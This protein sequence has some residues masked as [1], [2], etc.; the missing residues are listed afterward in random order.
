MINMSRR[1]TQQTDFTL[2]VLVPRPM[3]SIEDGRRLLGLFTNRF[4]RRALERF[5][6]SEPLKDR[7][8]L[9]APDAA[10]EA[11]WGR[12]GFTFIAEGPETLLYVHATPPAKGRPGRTRVTLVRFQS[13]SRDDFE[14]VCAFVSEASSI[15][16]ADFAAAHVLTTQELEGRLEKIRVHPTVWPIAPGEQTVRY[17][18]DRVHREGF[19]T[20]LQN[21][22]NVISIPTLQKG[23]PHLSWFTVFGRPYIEMFGRE[24]I[25]S[26]PAFEV[27]EISEAAVR[28]QLT[29]DLEDSQKSWDNFARIRKEC[30]EHLG[31]DA[32]RGDEEDPTRRAS[33]VPDFF[34]GCEQAESEA[35]RRG[36][37][38]RVGI[39]GPGGSLRTIDIVRRKDPK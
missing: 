31:L 33:R 1:K 36:V 20:V 7:F 38:A 30:E 2:T 17:L 37:V 10:L 39:P 21:M 15:W 22:A 24:R 26:I 9:S 29:E 34:P 27:R 28:V 16:A 35:Q 14:A 19:A 25:F 32:F 8:D 12:P 3:S 11:V 6:E 18:R 23:L 13:S 4:P 5:G